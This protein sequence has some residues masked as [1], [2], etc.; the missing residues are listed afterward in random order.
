MNILGE[1]KPDVET[2]IVVKREGSDKTVKI[3][4]EAKK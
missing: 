3:I 4:P 1:L 2:D